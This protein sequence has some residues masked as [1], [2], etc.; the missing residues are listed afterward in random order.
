MLTP[1]KAEEVKKWG[2]VCGWLALGRTE[3]VFLYRGTEQ[4]GCYDSPFGNSLLF[5]NAS[6]QHRKAFLLILALFA[7]YRPFCLFRLEPQVTPS[8]FRIFRLHPVLGRGWK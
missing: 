4:V 2:T 6:D 1:G 7:P 3:R 5:V 8:M